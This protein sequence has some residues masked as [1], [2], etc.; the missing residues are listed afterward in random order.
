MNES[1]WAQWAQS[2]HSIVS[3]QICCC[4]SFKCVFIPPQKKEKKSSTNHFSFTSHRHNAGTLSPRVLTQKYYGWFC[5]YSPALLP[6]P[7]DEVLTDRSDEVF[8]WAPTNS[9]VMWQLIALQD[10]LQQLT[11]H[12]EPEPRQL[13]ACC[14]TTHKNRWFI[15]TMC[16][17]GELWPY[18]YASDTFAVP[19]IESQPIGLLMYTISE[20]SALCIW[21]ILIFKPPGVTWTTCHMIFCFVTTADRKLFLD[22]PLLFLVTSTFLP[23]VTVVLYLLFYSETILL[24]QRCTKC[25]VGSCFE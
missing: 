13:H 8:C 21:M 11:S 22:P 14:C 10:A 12:S 16:P 19:I 4:W 24:G 15:W 25:W 23:A 7:P 6:T 2:Y 20:S 18:K 1:Q 5:Q 17:A 9:P 3:V